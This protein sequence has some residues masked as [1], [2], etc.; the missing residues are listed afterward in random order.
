MKRASRDT[1][2]TAIH[3]LWERGWEVNPQAIQEF[4]TRGNTDY[5]LEAI[6]AIINEIAVPGAKERWLKNFYWNSQWA[7]DHPR[8]WPIDPARW[9]WQKVEQ[10]LVGER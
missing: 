5:P 4:L 7:L 10:D 8:P 1:V 2:I 3:V 9:K 6:Q